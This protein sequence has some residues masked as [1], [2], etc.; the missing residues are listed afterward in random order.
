[1]FARGLFRCSFLLATRFAMFRFLPLIGPSPV[2]EVGCWAWVGTV[3]KPVP[4]FAQLASLA[5]ARYSLRLLLWCAHVVASWFCS[6]YSS[7]PALP[8]PLLLFVFLT[9]YH[10]QASR[11]EPDP[12]VPFVHAC[13]CPLHVRLRAWP[14]GVG[15]P[16]GRPCR[17]CCRTRASSANYVKS[18]PQALLCGATLLRSGTPPSTL[19]VGRGVP[20]TPTHP[21]HPPSTPPL[22]VGCTSGSGEGA[23]LRVDWSCVCVNWWKCRCVLEEHWQRFV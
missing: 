20:R 7:L 17:R 2:A 12:G 5:C 10:L 19:Q 8:I 1:M 4:C 22:L 18:L 21:V 9:A 16:G 3:H 6:Q 11:T 14:R 15:V 23:R 13:S